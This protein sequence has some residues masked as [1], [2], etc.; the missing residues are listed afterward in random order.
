MRDLSALTA[1]DF[2]SAVDT[3]FEVAHGD[4]D[5][6][7]LRLARVVV[8]GERPGHRSPFTLEFVGPS[9]PVLDHVI[10]VVTHPDM[11]AF[12]LF[13]GPVVSPADGTT[14]EAVFN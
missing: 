6:V 9:S 14:Y 3:E 2:E 7:A 4:G 13:L 5:W 11:G 10:H 12:E 1:A 8:A